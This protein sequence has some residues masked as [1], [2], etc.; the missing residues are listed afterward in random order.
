MRKRERGC[1]RER[2]IENERGWKGVRTRK[3]NGDGEVGRSLSVAT[4]LYRI[5]YTSAASYR[6][7]DDVHRAHKYVYP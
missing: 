3:K 6:R 1:G 2:E 4:T 7:A 5:I